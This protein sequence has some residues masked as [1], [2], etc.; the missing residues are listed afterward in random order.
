MTT[1]RRVTVLMGGM[2]SEREVSLVSGKNV[3]EALRTAGYIVSELDA[4]SDLAALVSNLKEQKPDVVF[5]ALHGRYGE[6]GCIQ[7]ILEWMKIPYTHS[8]VRA[9]A[10]AMDKAAARAVFLAAGLPVA[11]GKVVS[12]EELAK[13]DPLP[14][15]YVIKPLNEGSS[16]GVYIIREGS[17]QRKEIAANWSYGPYALAEEF[18]PGRE[19]TVGVMGD[20]ALTITDITPTPGQGHDFYDYDAKYKTGGST[21]VLPAQLDETTAQQALEASVK[22]HQALGCSGASRADFRLDDTGSG[23]ARLVLLEVNTQ[24]GM[25][26]TSLLPEQAAWCGISYPE[27][28]SWLTEQALNK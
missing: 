17:D 21:H 23:P 25:T 5:N 9:S 26:A 14:A 18:I 6:D 7:G 16:V 1:A 10:V 27:L 8:D 19:I 11:K 13:A 24:P 4:S 22:A 2:S 15:P 3:A 20:R 28:C 12:I